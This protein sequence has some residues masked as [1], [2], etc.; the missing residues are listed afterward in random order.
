MIR[1]ATAGDIVAIA[2]L[3]ADVF[4]GDA[5]SSSQVEA[6]VEAPT[7]RVAVAEAEGFLIGFA[8]I[9]LAGGVGDLTRI[10]VAA[11][12]RRTG[13]ATDLLA[14][15][16]TQASQAGAERLLL[17]VAD[18]NDGAVAFYVARGFEEIARRP[19]YYASGD[20]ALVFA[21]ALG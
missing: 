13:V 15:V 19:R 7:H 1:D 2:T 10:A 5:W 6:E 4:G 3:E 18:S 16:E 14:A 20:D 8:A 21:R 17:E 12:A 9:A 11:S